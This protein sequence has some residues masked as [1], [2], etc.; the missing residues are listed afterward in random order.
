VFEK[1]HKFVVER[2][3]RLEVVRE[4]VEEEQVVV[5]VLQQEVSIDRGTLT[6]SVCLV[7]AD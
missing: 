6:H 1:L 3:K 7:H 4:V 5:A 2:L